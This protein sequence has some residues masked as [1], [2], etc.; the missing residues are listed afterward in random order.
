MNRNLPPLSTLRAFDAAASLQSFSLAADQLN[1]THGAVS[2]AVRTLEEHLGVGLFERS[3]RKVTLSRAG[4]IYAEQVRYALNHLHAGAK[5][6]EAEAEAEAESGILSVSTIDSFATRWLLPKL[7]SFNAAHPEIDMR[8]MVSDELVDFVRDGIDIAVRYGHGG[9]DSDEY[10]LLLSEEI[11]PVCSPK[12]LEKLGVPKTPDDLSGFTL[13][14]DNFLVTW[15]VWLSAAGATN[16]NDTRGPS[17][18]LSSHVV[19][20]AING[21][22]VA[23]GRGA[24]VADDIAAGRLIRLFEVNLPAPFSYYVVYPKKALQRKKVRDF[25]DWLFDQVKA[26]GPRERNENQGGGL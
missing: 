9:Y 8:L 13:I 20:A 4:E 23:L 5:L 11:F 18:N 25:R 1:L 7:Q 6:I 10:E 16:V 15:R 12:L 19:Q 22:G 21:E 26:D 2:R 14:H 3:H 17:Y 24:L